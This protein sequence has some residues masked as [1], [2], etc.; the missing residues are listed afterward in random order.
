MEELTE[1]AAFK[2]AKVSTIDGV[3]ADYVD[4]FGLIRPSNT[5]PILVLRF[6]ADSEAAL[7]RIQSDFKQQILQID[8]ELA[9][10]F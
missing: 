8:S 6:E 5:T 4:G 3:R 9:L 7:T 2:D 10:P 1:V